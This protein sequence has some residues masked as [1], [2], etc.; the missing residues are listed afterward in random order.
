MR[1][2]RNLTRIQRHNSARTVHRFYWMK[3]RKLTKLKI[4]IYKGF[5]NN[6]EFD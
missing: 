4:Q 3:K 6:N 2:K 1:V 5:Y